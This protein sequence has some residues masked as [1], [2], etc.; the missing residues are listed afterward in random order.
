MART[1]GAKAIPANT[2]VAVAGFLATRSKEGHLRYGTVS[3]A[4]KV[5]RIS[6]AAIKQIWALRNDPSSL[7]VK[8]INDPVFEYHNS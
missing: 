1:L 3:L 8:S 7:I 6:Q 4:V 2:C 5:F